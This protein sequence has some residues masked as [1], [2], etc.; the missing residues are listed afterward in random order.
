MLV[1][2]VLVCG[3]QPFGRGLCLLVEFFDSC[4]VFA[5][6]LLPYVANSALD[7]DSL[8]P[9]IAVMMTSCGFLLHRWCSMAVRC[10][11]SEDVITPR[12][13]QRSGGRY[14]CVMGR[15]NEPQ[16][17]WHPVQSRKTAQKQEHIAGVFGHAHGKCSVGA[18]NS[19][20][21]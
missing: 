16:G 17:Q 2:G 19:E 9:A 11:P 15:L 7:L 14:W 10:G 8:P 5:Q 6:Q 20:R 12:L 4:G 21:L 3:R 1:V 18:R 13:H